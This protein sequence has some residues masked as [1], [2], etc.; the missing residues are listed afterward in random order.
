MSKMKKEKPNNYWLYEEIKSYRKKEKIRKNE[1]KVERKKEEN[2]ERW[3]H[4]CFIIFLYCVE[5]ASRLT[6]ISSVGAFFTMKQL[7]QINKYI[8]TEISWLCNNFFFFP[9]IALH[10]FICVCPVSSFNL[11]FILSSLIF[12]LLKLSFFSSVFHCAPPTYILSFLLKCFLS[13]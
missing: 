10:F 1:T 2:K 9:S 13:F 8:Y 6:Y 5:V 4:C 7:S 12:F 3:K 11:L